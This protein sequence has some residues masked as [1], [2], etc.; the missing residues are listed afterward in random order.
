[1]WTNKD[2]ESQ[3]KQERKYLPLGGTAMPNRNT[4]K[5]ETNPAPDPASDL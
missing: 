2:I 5:K 4:K 1:M 3:R